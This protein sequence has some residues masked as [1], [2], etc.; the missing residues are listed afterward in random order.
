VGEPV[1]RLGSPLM[2]KY[3]KF[4]VR[5]GYPLPG[6]YANSNTK[7]GCQGVK[8]LMLNLSGLRVELGT[9]KDSEMNNWLLG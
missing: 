1:E 8:S 6:L 2:E 9:K 3:G 7:L 5:P 4:S